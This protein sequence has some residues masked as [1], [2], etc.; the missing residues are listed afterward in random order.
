MKGIE[1]SVIAFYAA[2]TGIEEEIKYIYKD[3]NPTSIGISYSNLLD[4]DGDGG[5]VTDCPSDLSDSDDAC[6]K[7]T[8]LAPASCGATNGCVQSL[9]VYKGTQRAIQ[10]TY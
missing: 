7:I 6:Y 5:S 2:D 9:G 1:N 4:L 10:V 3:N 8:I